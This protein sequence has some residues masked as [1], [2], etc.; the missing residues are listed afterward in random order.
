MALLAVLALAT[1]TVVAVAPL[2]WEWRAAVL[3]LLAVAAIESLERVVP[4]RGARAVRCFRV[5]RDGAI[6]VE[7]ASG[8]R[9]EGRV[10]PGSFVAPWLVIV[11]WRRPGALRDSTI[12]V[13][14]DMA[15]AE[16]LRRLRVLLR[17]S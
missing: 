15:P 2:E 5:Q 12:L 4:L 8:A 1:A 13:L 6:E 10:R 17:W 7:T 11:R 16:D 3:F 9:L 14:P